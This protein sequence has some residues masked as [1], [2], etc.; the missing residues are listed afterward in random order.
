MI[1]LRLTP[2]LEKVAGLV[3][4]QV[5]ADI[6]TDHGK[7]PAFLIMEGRISHAIACD[8]RPGPLKACQRTAK[9]FGL[10]DAFAFRL[11]DGLEP[12]KPGEADSIVIAGMGGE[13]IKQILNKQD[14]VAKAASEIILQPMTSL[15]EVRR[16]AVESGYTISEE[17]LVKEGR[18]LYSVIKLIPVPSED[19]GRFYDLI[20]KILI[21]RQD[22]NLP[23]L[24]DREA[25][26]L[27][28]QIAGLKHAHNSQPDQITELESLLQKVRNVG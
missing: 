4:G 14:A 18:K 19:P 27:E 16:F 15:P 20:P 17:V 12:L 22:P 24:I 13:L 28:K 5:L 8:V 21:D 25:K 11:G 10:E 23:L 7:L 3:S 9:Q 1:S 26:K 6:G 2:R